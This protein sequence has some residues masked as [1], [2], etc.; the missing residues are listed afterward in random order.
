MRLLADPGTV[1]FG[2]KVHGGTVVKWIDEAEAGDACASG[3][4]G[5]YCATVDVDGIRLRRPILI[6]DLVDVQASRVHPH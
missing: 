6:G 1:S 4:A 3:W 5:R 2:G